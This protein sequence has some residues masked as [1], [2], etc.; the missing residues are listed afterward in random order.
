MILLSIVLAGLSIC[1]TDC[2]QFVGSLFVIRGDDGSVG[3]YA[4]DCGKSDNPKN[5]DLCYQ[6]KTDYAINNYINLYTYTRTSLNFNIY[7][8]VIQ[9]AQHHTH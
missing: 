3:K 2:R 5:V 1:V 4:N 9:P 7:F 6:I 8:R